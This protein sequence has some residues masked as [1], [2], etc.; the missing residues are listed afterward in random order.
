LNKK[1][2]L[3]VTFTATS[4]QQELLIPTLLELGFSGFLEEEPYLKSYMDVSNWK[5]EKFEI[6]KSDLRSLLQT[7]SSNA[8]IHFRTFEEENWNQQ[9]EQSL[10]PVEIGKK[11]VIKP[12]WCQYDNTEDRI[13][14]QIDPKMSFGTG[15]H[16]TTRLTTLLLEQYVTQGM[17]MLDVGT[18]TGVLAIAGVKLGASFAVGTDL[19]EWSIEN[20]N[21][22]IIA[23]Q[24]ADKIEIAMKPVV[25]FKPEEFDL[26]TANL[27]L[28]TNIDLL[29]DFKRVLKKNGVLLLSGLLAIDREKM[30]EAISDNGFQLK[31][32]ITENEWIAVAAL[33]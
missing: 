27:T 16:E 6:L 20:A 26:I 14:I 29:I 7:I 28:N 33:K 25:H 3:E 30:L 5:D 2:F 17:K 4:S 18:G 24:V 1:L 32:V 31:E 21:E 22:N 9:W 15:Y 19:D 8:E 12:S 11:I 23:N 10:K 13:V